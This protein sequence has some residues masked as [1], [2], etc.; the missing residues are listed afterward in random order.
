M[1][2]MKT[3]RGGLRQRGWRA[4]AFVLGLV[5][6]L[7]VQAQG[8][9]SVALSPSSIAGGSGGASTATVQL[10]SVAPPGG[11]NVSIASSNPA[12]AAAMTTVTVPAGAISA[13]VVVG[14]NAGY[15]RYSGLAF[16]AVITANANGTSASATLAVSAQPRPADVRSD[17]SQRS[18]AMCGGTV[19]ATRGEK[20]ILYNCSLAPDLNT[21]GVCT[22]RQECSVACQTRQP[23]GFSYSDS[24]ATTG[25]APLILGAT[26]VSGAALLG[27]TFN[28]PVASQAPPLDVRATLTS[29]NAAASGS[30][31]GTILFA[32]G[33]VSAPAAVQTTPVAGPSFAKLGV[34]V[35]VPQSLSG[36][37]VYNSQRLSTTWLA[38]VPGDGEAAI[39]VTG[40]SVAPV[41]VVGGNATTA[42]LQ[43]NQ[44]APAGGATVLINSSRT[45]VATA[46]STVTVPAGMSSWPFTVTSVA[47]TVATPVT[48]SATL[49][50][51]TTTTSLTVNPVVSTPLPAPTL[52][53]P[54]SRARVALGSSI[55]FD[56][57]DVAGAASYTLEVDN[58]STIA[59]PLV[60]SLTTATSQAQVSNLPAGKYWW[61]VRA[62]SST[63]TAGAWSAVRQVEVK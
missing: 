9:A 31:L 15:R 48:L 36:G 12:L 2:F 30:P 4:A 14:T 1:D 34:S 44:P 3:C 35:L 59:A 6:S 47:V 61:R 62:S 49:S 7:A 8:V 40:F 29:D 51:L 22:F 55:N 60:A 23:N 42:T 38:M 26:Q 63:G 58:S 13:T 20:G 46:P 10:S 32:L 25:P 53:A 28:S 54:A 19:P 37:A 41:S 50:G 33:A 52:L 5:A 43:L 27:G 24:C 57:S 18:G 21:T 11:L 17:S 56:W 45:D 39:A 16:N